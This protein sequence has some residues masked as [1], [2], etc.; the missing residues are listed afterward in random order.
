[1]ETL[2]CLDTRRQE[3]LG[4]AFTLSPRLPAAWN[5]G[6]AH[7]CVHPPRLA[8]PFFPR[9]VHLKEGA[10]WLTVLGHNPPQQ[11]GLGSRTMRTMMPVPMRQLVS[12]SLQQ[13]AKKGERSCSACFLFVWSRTSAHEM[14]PP[15]VKTDLPSSMMYLRQPLPG[16][17][18]ACLQGESRASDIDINPHGAQAAGSFL[19]LAN[20][21]PVNTL[22]P[23]SSGHAGLRAHT[24]LWTR[25]CDVALFCMVPTHSDFPLQPGQ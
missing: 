8:F 1:M 12:L 11:S 19:P 5:P 2:C 7:R 16:M 22:D 20:N 4:P 25:P 10:L 13:E 17:S 9:W 21:A 15:I 6:H 3:H 18:L 24:C 14:T 23:S